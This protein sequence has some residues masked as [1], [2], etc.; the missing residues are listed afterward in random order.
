MEEH[1][2][3]IVIVFCAAFMMGAC[4]S[5]FAFKPSR[6]KPTEGVTISQKLYS[7]IKWD[8]HTIIKRT[9][10][11]FS[12]RANYQAHLNELEEVKND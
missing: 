4:I 10:I 12:D 8:Y 5:Y 6:L 3:L 1:I 9:D 7:K 11:S 2:K